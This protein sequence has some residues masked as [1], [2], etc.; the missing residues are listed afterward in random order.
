MNEREAWFQGWPVEKIGGPGSGWFAP[1]R[2][3]HTSAVTGK[4]AAQMRAELKR[5]FKRKMARAEQ[6]RARV[7]RLSEE[8]MSLNPIMG[9]LHGERHKAKLEGRTADLKRINKE[10]E[11]LEKKRDGIYLKSAKAQNEYWNV[12]NSIRD[13][14]R[15]KLKVTNPAEFKTNMGKLRKGKIELQEGSDAFASMMGRGTLDGQTVTVHTTKGNR[16]HYD[17]SGVYLPPIN[18]RSTVMVHE[19]GH[20]LE[21]RDPD[22]H[23]KAV[24][25]LKG[26]TGGEVSKPLRTLT[27]NPGYRDSEWARKN[28][29]LDPYMG[30]MY[31]RQHATEIVSMGMEYFYSRPVEFATKDPGYFDFMYNLVRGE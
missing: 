12:K 15:E 26:R 17:N 14:A 6:L 10:I 13:G 18:R 5:D 27:G 23:T 24:T 8:Q 7:D 19:L 28:K 29:F 3:T 1:P 20:W 2:G 11:A 22:V 16:G 21:D 25:F 9:N 31:P 4:T 30:K